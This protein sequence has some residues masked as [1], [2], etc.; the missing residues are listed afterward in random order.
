ML[1]QKIKID[2]K[3]Y[4]VRSADWDGD[5]LKE[6]AQQLEQGILFYK[7]TKDEISAV[8]LA[9]LAFAYDSV[10][11]SREPFD[12]QIKNS[13]LIEAQLQKILQ[14]IL[15]HIQSPTESGLK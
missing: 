8:V 4:T 6:A 10:S 2:N 12:M 14:K 1:E 15:T 3:E 13:L 11:K 5:V 7:K 9:A